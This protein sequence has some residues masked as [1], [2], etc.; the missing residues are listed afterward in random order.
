[1]LFAYEFNKKED[2]LLTH[3]N[4]IK[5]KINNMHLIVQNQAQEKE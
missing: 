5:K 1:M 3:I 4:S 2:V